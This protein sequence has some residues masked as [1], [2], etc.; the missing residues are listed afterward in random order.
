MKV[1]CLQGFVSKWGR[2]YAWSW[3]HQNKEIYRDEL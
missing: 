2:W 1:V 3:S